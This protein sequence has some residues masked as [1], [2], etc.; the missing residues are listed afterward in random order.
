M[1]LGLLRVLVV[2]S[3]ASGAIWHPLVQL[4]GLSVFGVVALQVPGGASALA[5]QY[6]AACWSVPVLYAAVALTVGRRRPLV[7]SRSGVKGC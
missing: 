6:L 7:W 5:H 4:L 1:P 3:L 2:S